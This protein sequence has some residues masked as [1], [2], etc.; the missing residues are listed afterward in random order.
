MHL[1][2]FPITYP[3]MI[4]PIS[5]FRMGENGVRGVLCADIH[6]LPVASK[7]VSLSIISHDFFTL[8]TSWILHICRVI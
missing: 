8:Y 4:F 6:G 5:L 1:F 3:P 2:P 7:Y